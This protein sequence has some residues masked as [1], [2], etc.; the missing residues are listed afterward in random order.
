MRACA[1]T[2]NVAQHS[3]YRP[4][5]ATKSKCVIVSVIM[6]CF[7]S[8]CSGINEASPPTIITITNESSSAVWMDAVV[9]V[10]YQPEC[11]YFVAGG[12]AEYIE[13]S[14]PIPSKIVVRW[15]KGDEMH[16]ESEPIETQV[17]VVQPPSTK[18]IERLHLKLTSEFKWTGEFAP[19]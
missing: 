5:N 14:Q 12:E 4:H 7:T 1:D 8:G 18:R 16:P 2:Q 10:S 17:D 3:R 13:A 9:G 19:K 11:L 15:W 6:A